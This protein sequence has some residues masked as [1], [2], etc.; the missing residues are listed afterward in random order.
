MKRILIYGLSAEVGGTERYFLTLYRAMDLNRLRFDFLFPHD[1]GTI[2]YENVIRDAGGRIFR[3]YYRWCER[4]LPGAV[5]VKQ[6]FDRHPDEWDGVYI[7]VQAVDTAYRLLTEAEHRGL[8]YR[9]MHAHSSGYFHERTLKNRLYELYFH[10]TKRK[11]V[12]DFLACSMAA[13]KFAFHSSDFTVIPNAVEFD[14]FRADPVKRAQM[15]RSFQ[16]P[17]DTVVLG[18]CARL[19]RLKNMDF[20][21]KIFRAFHEKKVNSCFL[22]A[23]DGP[24]RQ[25]L[26]GLIREYGLESCVILAGAVDNVWDYLQMMDVFLLPSRFEGFGIA[27]LEAQ[28]AGLECFTTADTVP[29]EVNVTGHVHFIDGK[30]PEEIWAEKILDIDP[31]RYDETLLLKNS[32]YTVEAAVKKLAECFEEAYERTGKNISDHS[33][34]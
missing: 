11:N 33:G 20:A 9:V 18:S 28:A 14:R 17:D 6:F 31:V 30:D 29:Q 2:S 22:V 3:E 1:T 23:G 13:G 25:T 10:L 27:L 15:R 34:V 4:K 5:S 26:E 24:Q 32:E 8:K 7:N 16:I 19:V 12:T 21:L